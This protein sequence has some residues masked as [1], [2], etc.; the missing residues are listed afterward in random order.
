M[1]TVNDQ[2]HIIPPALEEYVTLPEIGGELLVFEGQFTL[3]AGE[4]ECGV[5]GKVFYS[6]CEKIQLLMEGEVDGSGA[7]VWFGGTVDLIIDGSFSGRV[8]IER[9]QGERIWGS[10]YHF[11]NKRSSSCVSFRWCYFNAPKIFGDGVRRGRNV[12]T[13]RL[14]FQAG[15]YQVKLE[16]VAGFQPQ[17]RHRKISH[18]CELTRQDGEPI[19]AEAA[20]DEIRLFSRFVS[21]FAGCQH[22]PF[23]IEGLD[24]V[25]IRYEFHSVGHEKSLVGVSSWKP[26]FKDRDLVSLWPKFRAKCYESPDRYDV[27][28]TVIHWYLEANMNSGLLEG[29]VLLG[30]TGLELLSKEIVGKELGNQEIVEDFLTRLHISIKLRP[31]EISLTRNYLTHYKTEERRR[32]YTS[33][34]FEEKFFRLEIILHIL[35]LAILY[36]LGY[37]GHYKDRFGSKWRGEDVK[38]VPWM[39]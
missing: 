23:F 36:W 13:D 27:L 3:K 16:N 26:D 8:F 6:F 4:K 12:A 24:G 2:A 15:G 18:I 22:A 10:V 32:R 35:E 33:L 19:T 34:T 38:L 30:F 5:D 7:I 29:A 14:V 17:K 1:S 20:I 9:N 11:E 31:E 21:F 25:A 37:E 28:N 39:S